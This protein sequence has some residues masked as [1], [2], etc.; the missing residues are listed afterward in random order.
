MSSSWLSSGSGGWGFGRRVVDPEH[1][2]HEA[3]AIATA[4]PLWPT[5][6]GPKVF[7]G[8]SDLEVVPNLSEFSIEIQL[9]PTDEPLRE[10]WERNGTSTERNGTSTHVQHVHVIS[11]VE[12]GTLHA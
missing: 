5:F 10:R 2:R 12:N 11:P 1:A 7:E 8:S 4:P 6:T 9:Q 3:E